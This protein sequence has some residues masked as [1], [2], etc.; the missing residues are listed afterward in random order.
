M[1]P[2]RLGTPSDATSAQVGAV[3]GLPGR[4]RCWRN[5]HFR[6]RSRRCPASPSVRAALRHR[7]DCRL[8][9]R[10]EGT[11]PAAERLGWGDSAADWQE[12]VDHADVVDVVGILQPPA[13]PTP[14]S[15][16]PPCPPA[17]TCCARNSS[18]TRPSR[19]SAWPP[20]RRSPEGC[21]YCRTVVDLG[22]CDRPS[23]GMISDRGCATALPDLLPTTGLLP[24]A[25]PI[26]RREQR[27]DPCPSS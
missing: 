3:D 10:P 15:R 24:F 2:L 12:V 26:D 25:G 11:I 22:L 7:H 14:T 8:R 5:V 16:S 17:N 19:P 9:P 4:R 13:T 21:L 20:P 23:M 27:R 6:R 1:H 18:P